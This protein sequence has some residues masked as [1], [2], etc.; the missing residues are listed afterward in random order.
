MNKEYLIITC[1]RMSC[2]LQVIELT[3]LRQILDL[4]V[5]LCQHVQSQDHLPLALV[6]V[7]SRLNNVGVYIQFKKTTLQANNSLVTECILYDES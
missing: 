2:L 3:V 5:N 6:A 7:C 4:Y 1:L